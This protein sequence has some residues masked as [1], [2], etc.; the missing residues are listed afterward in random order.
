MLGLVRRRREL[1]TVEPQEE[2]ALCPEE[3]VV[4]RLPR[5]RLQ[6]WRGPRVDGGR[7]AH[8]QVDGRA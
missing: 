3:A 2:A 1:G 4:R 6:A 5:Q 7:V 8:E